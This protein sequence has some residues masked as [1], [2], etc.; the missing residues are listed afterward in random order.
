MTH[1]PQ[2]PQQPGQPAGPLP[3]EESSTRR[4]W[5]GAG[6][7][8]V[9]AAVAAAFSE[10][11]LATM[12]EP[13]DDPPEDLN[14]VVEPEVPT[15]GD[16]GQVQQRDLMVLL[17]RVELAARDLYEE[18]ITTG[19]APEAAVA[20]SR[21][22]RAYADAISGAIGESARGRN[23]GLFDA[24]SPAFRSPSVA[25]FAGTAAELETQLA[26][27]YEQAVAL[28]ADEN[29]IPLLASIAMMEARHSVVLGTLAGQA[30]DVSALLNP[31]LA[32]LTLQELQ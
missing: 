5:L 27:T 23:D 30:G 26:T 2:T 18:A 13:V 14:A 28:V 7:G 6:L 32:P 9:G 22:H 17:M 19:A 25:T 29:W 24:L 21:Q 3:T 12:P 10:T 15:E 31:D 4:R 8:A 16:L 20:M 11:A 1:S